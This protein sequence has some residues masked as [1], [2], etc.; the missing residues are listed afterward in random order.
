MVR[1]T[2]NSRRGQVWS[3]GPMFSFSSP[4]LKLPLYQ[5]LL[6]HRYF[7]A[8][9]VYTKLFLSGSNCFTYRPRGHL[10]MTELGSPK[11]TDPVFVSSTNL[12]GPVTV[13]WTPV[14][15]DDHT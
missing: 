10:E 11:N 2:I 4:V 13:P 9:V 5:P 8:K 15:V 3:L 6:W 14:W 1:S 12:S 7:W